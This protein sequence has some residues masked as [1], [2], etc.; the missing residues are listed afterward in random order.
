MKYLAAFLIGIIVGFS[1]AGIAFTRGVIRGIVV[2]T[3]KNKL[4]KEKK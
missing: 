3:V 1:V 4:N 2:N